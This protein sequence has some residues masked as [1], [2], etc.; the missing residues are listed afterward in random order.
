MVGTLLSKLGL[1][2][3][4]AG[5]GFMGGMMFQGKVLKPNIK[6][7][8]VTCPEAAPCICNPPAVEVQSFDVNKI[9]NM[10]SFT[11]APQFQGS[12]QVAG[13]DSTALRNMIRQSIQQEFK[14]LKVK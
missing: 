9:K 6:V 7:E 13:V 3:L 5:G 11:Y 12:I 4:V 14:K 2:L 10:R 8:T 1:P